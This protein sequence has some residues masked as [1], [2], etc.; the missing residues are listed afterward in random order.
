MVPRFDYLGLMID[1]SRLFQQE[2]VL[3]GSR[4]DAMARYKLHRPAPHLHDARRMRTEI[5]KYPFVSP[6][7]S[8]P[9]ERPEAIVGEKVVFADNGRKYLRVSE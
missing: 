2:R 1:V 9:R 3:E 4:V 7:L 5:K 8:L 6:T